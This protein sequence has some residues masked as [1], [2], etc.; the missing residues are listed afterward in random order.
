MQP[1][2]IL[3]NTQVFN[4]GPNPRSSRRHNLQLLLTSFQTGLQKQSEGAVLAFTS[5][6]PQEGVTHVIQSFAVELAKHSERRTLIIS[7]ER[8][9]TLRVADYIRMPE[10][11]TRTNI[12]N[13]WVLGVEKNGNGKSNGNGNGQPR[14]KVTRLED[15]SEFGLDRIEALRL[16]F[17]NILIDCR[18]LKVSSE[19]AVLAATVDGVVVVVEAGR[20]RRDE[21]KNAQRTIEMAKGNFLGI[22]L[23][24]RR[25]PVPEWLYKRL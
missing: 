25:Y 13:L 17:P 5:A 19:A 15:E 11:C 14:N 2:E 20:T 21:I 10:C 16:T 6:A 3:T 1:A 8:L 22:I 23:N 24:K 7:A 4:G 18:S 12:D 9:Q